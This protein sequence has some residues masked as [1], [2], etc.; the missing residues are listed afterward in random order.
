MDESPQGTTIFEDMP[1][2]CP[3]AR[4]RQFYHPVTPYDQRRSKLPS[5][6]EMRGE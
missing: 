4:Q 2:K 3:L 1:P 5:S 6:S